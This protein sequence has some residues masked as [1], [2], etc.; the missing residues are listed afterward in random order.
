MRKQRWFLWLGLKSLRTLD[1]VAAWWRQEAQGEANR[2]DNLGA[3]ST[4]L[5]NRPLR[6]GFGFC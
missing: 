1:G 3:S 5:A 6:A 4:K 2:H